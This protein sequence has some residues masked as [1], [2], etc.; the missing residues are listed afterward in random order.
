MVSIAIIASA[1]PTN[2]ALTRLEKSLDPTTKMAPITRTVMI[3]IDIVGRRRTAVPATASENLENIRKVNKCNTKH[4]EQAHWPDNP[5]DPEVRLA[6]RKN[7]LETQGRQR[8]GRGGEEDGYFRQRAGQVAVAH[9]HEIGDTLNH[10]IA[11]VKTGFHSVCDVVKVL[12]QTVVVLPL[13]C[14]GIIIII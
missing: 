11:G 13:L 1:I 5:E 12:Q 10:V 7:A 4:D 9:G 6:R 14:V 8:N 2:G 3:V